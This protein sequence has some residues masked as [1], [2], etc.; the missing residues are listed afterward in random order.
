MMEQAKLC[1]IPIANQE[2]KQHIWGKRFLEKMK[3]LKG[4]NINN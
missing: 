4:Q 1:L 2:K 3:I